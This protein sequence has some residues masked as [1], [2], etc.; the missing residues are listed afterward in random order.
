MSKGW[1]I[2]FTDRNVV[3]DIECPYY[4]EHLSDSCC[5]EECQ[6][7]LKED[8]LKLLKEQEAERIVRKQVKHENSDGSVEKKGGG[9]I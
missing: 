6:E 9:Q 8:V 4:I 2:A 1:N 7:N 5:L 3:G